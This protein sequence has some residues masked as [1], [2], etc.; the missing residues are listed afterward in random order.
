MITFGQHKGLSY[1]H[2]LEH[3]KSYCSY[4]LKQEYCKGKFKEF[5]NFLKKKY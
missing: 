1:E 5:Q 3:E 4:V 2:M